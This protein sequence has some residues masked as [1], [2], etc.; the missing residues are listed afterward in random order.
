MKRFALLYLLALSLLTPVYEQ[1]RDEPPAGWFCQ[2]A[3]KDVLPDHVCA[4]KRMDHSEDCDEPPIEDST[5]AVFCHPKHC[6]CK[7]ICDPRQH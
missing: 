1:H 2:P 3:G 5:C 6:K 7:I 4:C